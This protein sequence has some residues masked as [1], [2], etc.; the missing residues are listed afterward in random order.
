MN[1]SKKNIEYMSKKVAIASKGRFY[2]SNEI[3][4]AYIQANGYND[5]QITPSETKGCSDYIEFTKDGVLEL[6]DK[7]D[8][9]P[10]YDYKSEQPFVSDGVI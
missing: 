6:F 2:L 7:F 8:G 9:E 4:I 3:S 5:I 1:V 10:F